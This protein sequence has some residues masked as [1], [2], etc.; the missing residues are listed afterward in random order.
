MPTI[1]KLCERFFEA[2]SDLMLYL[3]RDGNILNCNSAFL[4]AYNLTRDEVIGKKCHSIVHNAIFHIE[5]CPLLRAKESK[6]REEMEMI[7]GERTFRVSVDPILDDKGEISG[8]VHIATDI[9]SYKDLIIR[10]KESESRFKE[11][12]DSSKD[13]QIIM[14]DIFLEVND[15][16]AEIFSCEKKDLIGKH[17][18]DFSPKIQPDGS[19]SIVKSNT[20][21]NM[22]LSGVEQEFYWQHIDIKGRPIDTIV[23]LKKI[24]LGGKDYLLATVRDISEQIAYEKIKR[25]L[26]DKIS[27]LNKAE[28]LS[29][30][31]PG[32]VHDVNN[33][34]MMVYENIDALKRDLSNHPNFQQLSISIEKIKG[35]INSLNY[36]ITN[37]DESP[38]IFDLNNIVEETIKWLRPHRRKNLEITYKPDM[39]IPQITGFPL[40][41]QQ[42]IM[43]FIINSIEA[44]GNRDGMIRVTTGKK[45]YNSKILAQNRL[46]TDLTEGEYVFARIEDNGCGMSRETMQKIFEPFFTTKSYGRGLGM[47]SA[48]NS[49]EA[50]NG[51]L[52]VESEEG[53]GTTFEILLP[54]TTEAKRELGKEGSP[55][56]ITGKNILVVDSDTSIQNIV[57]RMISS[58]NHQGIAAENLKK[59]IEIIKEKKGDFCLILIDIDTIDINDKDI[60]SEIHNISRDIKIAFVGNYYIQRLIEQL[61]R[62]IRVYFLKKPFTTDD[63]ERLLN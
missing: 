5:G 33:A 20:L 39:S 29:N 56:R 31:I 1:D 54:L 3:D 25:I 35:L 28:S 60:I 2:S 58:M 45:M 24:V 27:L 23:H 51:G 46:N 63:L 41:I 38:Q 37:K 32:V 55:H 7:I 15:R 4:R 21:I 42:A 6:I 11:L 18:A 61:F 57:L 50:H 40:R 48:K 14:T 12:F 53:R 59:G 43:N 36:I 10:L 62:D 8:F 19:S 52:I 17:P 16:M 26:D 49:I 22:A 13:G 47:V 30:L 44:I 34:L 9:T